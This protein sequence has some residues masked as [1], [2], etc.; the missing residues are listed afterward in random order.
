[1]RVRLLETHAYILHGRIGRTGL[2]HRPV[3]DTNNMIA[4][5][6]NQLRVVGH[7]QH[8]LVAFQRR[9]QRRRLLH[10]AEVKTAGR[11][12][13]DQ[14]LFSSQNGRRNGYPLLLSTGQAHG[15]AFPQMG[16]IQHLQNTFNI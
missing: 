5:T 6:L 7:D 8:G 4:A 11:L 10:V 1:M 13:K 14:D 12:V 2:N 15:M 3:L 16:Q 9:K